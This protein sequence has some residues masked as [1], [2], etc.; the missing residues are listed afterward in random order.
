MA[1]EVEDARFAAKFDR[2]KCGIEQDFVAILC[3]TDATAGSLGI[4]ISDEEQTMLFVFQHSL[5]SKDIGYGFF[6]H[7]AA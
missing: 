4:S 3:G 5:S 7:H 6:R 2:W 1:A